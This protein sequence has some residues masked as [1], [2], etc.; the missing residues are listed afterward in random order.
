MSSNITKVMSVTEAS[1][2]HS[3]TPCRY[4]RCVCGSVASDKHVSTTFLSEDRSKS[5]SLCSVSLA[6][7]SP[8]A[9]KAPLVVVSI[10]LSL[11][12]ELKGSYLRG[13]DARQN[14]R[15]SKTIIEIGKDVKQ[16]EE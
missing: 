13:V 4:S 12:Y 10:V 6:S 11:L 16:K 3:L 5:S 8:S 7:L 2:S 1:I 14:A 15:A 9:C